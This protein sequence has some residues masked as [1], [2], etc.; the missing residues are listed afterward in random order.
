[1]NKRLIIAAAAGFA[2]GII[3]LIAL[4]F[5]LYSPNDVHH[6]ANFALYVNGERDPFDSFTFY[7]EVQ[8]CTDDELNNPLTRVHMHDQISN[9]VHVHDGAVTWGHFLANLGYGLTDT[10]LETDEGVFIDGEDDKQLKFILNGEPVNSIANQVIGSEDKLLIDY[11]EADQQTLY[12]RYDSIEHTA[13]EYN[14]KPD[15][16]SCSGGKNP[17]FVERLKHAI[18]I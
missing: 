3:W 6:H 1:M 13:G 8:S 16:S 15:P 14:Q 9:V 10:V 12:E 5:I 17:G 18:G 4:R 2:A 11:G 7:E